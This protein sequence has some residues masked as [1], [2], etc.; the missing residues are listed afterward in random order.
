[1]SELCLHEIVCVGCGGKDLSFLP[2]ARFVCDK[3]MVGHR[4]E[5]ERDEETREMLK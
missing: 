3:C 5:L 2:I 1:M 4:K